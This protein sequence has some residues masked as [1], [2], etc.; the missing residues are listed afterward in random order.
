MDFEK[1]SSEAGT[2]YI[3]A[4]CDFDSDNIIVYANNM[5]DGSMFH[6]LLAYQEREFWEGHPV[7]S[8]DTIYEEQEYAVLAAFYVDEYAEDNTDFQIDDFT[9]AKNKAEFDEALSYI[10]EKAIY[11]TDV[12]ASYGDKLITLI[13]DAENAEDGRFVV[14]AKKK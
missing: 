7:I 13:T 2:P 10:L 14:V 3:N 11:D 1:A 9:Q 6:G 4:D 5:E 12:D 8:F